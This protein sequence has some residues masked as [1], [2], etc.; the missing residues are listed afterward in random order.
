MFLS[1]NRPDLGSILPVIQRV[2]LALACAVN[3]PGCEADILTLQAK[4]KN[5][6]SS[7]ST[8]PYAFVACTVTALPLKPLF[9]SYFRTILHSD[10][11]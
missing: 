1:S 5:E 9:L 7:T 10:E 11:Y 4:V 2:P 8:P 3:P 6:G